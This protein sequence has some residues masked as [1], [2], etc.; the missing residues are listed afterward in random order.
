MMDPADRALTQTFVAVM[1]DPEAV[2]A[3]FDDLTPVEQWEV[4]ALLVAVARRAGWTPPPT[5]APK[6][7]RRI[8]LTT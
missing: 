6:R 1:G 5:T 3:A 4:A 8:P 7:A 2:P